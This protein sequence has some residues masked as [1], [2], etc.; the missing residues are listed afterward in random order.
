MN[1]TLPEG[2]LPITVAVNVTDWPDID[3]SADEVSFV[4]PSAADTT[5]SAI[6]A[7]HAEAA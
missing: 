2:L 3:G 6:D 4:E 5:V 1:L 7:L